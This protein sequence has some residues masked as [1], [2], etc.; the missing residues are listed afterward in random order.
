MINNEEI[1][2][3][4]SEIQTDFDV[5]NMFL[6]V[7]YEFFSMFILGFVFMAFVLVYDIYELLVTE[8]DD[9]SEEINEEIE[10]SDDDIDDNDDDEYEVEWNNI[11]NGDVVNHRDVVTLGDGWDDDIWW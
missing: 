9:S 11:G 3:N 10:I 1:N 6:Y 4:M 5:I 2:K 8:D 7:L